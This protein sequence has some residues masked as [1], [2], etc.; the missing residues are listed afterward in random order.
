LVESVFAATGP[1]A[2]V[3]AACRRVVR[4]SRE[5]HNW[6]QLVRFATVGGAGYAVNI[7]TFA[8]CVGPL[9]LDYRVAAVVS[10][11]VAVTNNFVLNRSWTFRKQGGA[12][13]FE[14]PR[15]LVVS[16]VAFGFSLLILTTL[17]GLGSPEVVAQAI[18]ICCATPLNFVGNKLWTFHR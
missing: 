5:R 11:L 18:A 12:V 9:S 3:S 15:F 2:G 13:A 8:V 14:A 17:V 10:F 7:V 16:L 4:G 1:F 6:L